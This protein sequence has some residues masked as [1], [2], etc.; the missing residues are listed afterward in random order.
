MQVNVFNPTNQ[1][2]AEHVRGHRIVV[3]AKS[4]AVVNDRLATEL[5][6]KAPSLKLAGGPDYKDEDFAAMRK[7]DKGGLQRLAEELMRGMKPQVAEFCKPQE[8]GK[9]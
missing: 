1:V 4:S 7:L 8:E 2:V 5:M 9:A 6:R 3:P